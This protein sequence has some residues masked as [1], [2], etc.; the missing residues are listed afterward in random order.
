MQVLARRTA[1]LGPLKRFLPPAVLDRLAVYVVDSAD[2]PE[3]ARRLLDHSRDMTSTLES[4]LGEPLRLRLL[5]RSLD[6]AEL[7][8]QVVLVGQRSARPAEFGA[9]V[10]HLD[11]FSDSAREDIIAGH[12]PLGTILARHDIPYRSRPRAFLRIDAD[13]ALANH[14]GA[15]AR[16]GD[17]L[18]G[19]TNVLETPSGEAL[20]RVVEILPPTL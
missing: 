11:R 6:D 2:L 16:P 7:R 19:R 15:V 20:A 4:W 13:A 10:I 3:T 1:D 14:L 18:W 9:I 17:R 12:F 5:A 8:R